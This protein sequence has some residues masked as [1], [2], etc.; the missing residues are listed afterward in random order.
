M[1][2]SRLSKVALCAT[3][4][5]V[6]AMS[7]AGTANAVAEPAPAP[8]PVAPEQRAAQSQLAQQQGGGKVRHGYVTRSVRVHLRPSTTAPVIGVIPRDSVIAI[9][10]MIR[11]EMAPG[12]NTWYKLAKRTGWVNA[13]YIRALDRIPFCNYVP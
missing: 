7:L 3:S 6:A 11:G 5:A 10:C 12:L 8:A 1:L 9:K 13:R 4:G 2:H